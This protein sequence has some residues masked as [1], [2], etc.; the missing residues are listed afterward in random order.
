MHERL[1][2]PAHTYDRR[3]LGLASY[4]FTR[5][6]ARGSVLASCMA[7]HPPAQGETCSNTLLEELP[8][9]EE[10]ASVPNLP[11]GTDDSHGLLCRA[12]PAEQVAVPYSK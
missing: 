4:L 6:L 12:Q 11:T 1:R 8:R 7:A 5:V 3:P 9:T 2:V 10:A